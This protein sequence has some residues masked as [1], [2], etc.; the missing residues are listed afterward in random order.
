MH[1]RAGGCTGRFIRAANAASAYT[2]IPFPSLADLNT[3]SERT[4]EELHA[5]TE[6][7]QSISKIEHT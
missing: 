2:D 3:A 4:A 1:S 6:L 7:R 5:L